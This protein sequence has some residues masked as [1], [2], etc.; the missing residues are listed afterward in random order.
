M[1]GYEIKGDKKL[2]KQLKR[3]AEM[4]D[5]FNVV[6]M[7]ASELQRK[8]QRNAT[9]KGHTDSSGEFIKPTGATKRSIRI[10]IGNK[11]LAAKVAPTT[12]YAIFLEFGTR[13]MDAQ[14]FMKPSF[15]TVQIQF[16]KDLQRLTK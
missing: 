14:P 11:G 12:N 3:N 2:L 1:S 15:L 13:F 6:K 7:N 9:F 5:I 10:E 16:I 4:K 8:A